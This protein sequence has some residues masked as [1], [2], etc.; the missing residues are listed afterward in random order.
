LTVN[1]TQCE[2]TTTIPDGSAQVYVVVVNYLAKYEVRPNIAAFGDST[3]MGVNVPDAVNEMYANYGACLA[4]IEQLSNTYYRATGLSVVA[5][6]CEPN[7]LENNFY[8]LR[9]E[10]FGQESTRLYL[11]QSFDPPAEHAISKVYT[12]ISNYGGIVAKVQGG[13]F[14]YYAPQVLNLSSNQLA[15][16]RDASQCSSQVSDAQ[17]IATAAGAQTAIVSCISLTDVPGITSLE[18][19]SDVTT[20]L[21]NNYG[22]HSP[23]YFSFAEC[24]QDKARLLSQAHGAYGAICAPSDQNPNEYNAEVFGR[25]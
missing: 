15:L 9:L 12:L 7:S 16:F 1:S 20:M 21:T 18:V 5:A 19:V 25:F 6:S 3:G 4:D 8:V 11:F 17:A 23:N 10:S 14:L 13:T 22:Y 2:T 24:Q